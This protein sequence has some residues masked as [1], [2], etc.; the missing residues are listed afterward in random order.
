MY[1][2]EDQHMCVLLRL[3]RLNAAMVLCFCQLSL[4][5]ARI[6]DE[7]PHAIATRMEECSSPVLDVRDAPVP[8]SHTGVVY[9]RNETVF[10]WATNEVQPP[11]SPHRDDYT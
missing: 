7:F 1:I 10:V 11:M 5:E 4:S 2:T 3:T 9:C 6:C 8:H